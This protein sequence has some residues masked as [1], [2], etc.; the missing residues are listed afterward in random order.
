MNT[1]Q[2][3]AF[4]TDCSAYRAEIAQI[5]RAAFKGR[6]GTGDEEVAI[7]AGLRASGDVIVELAMQ[8]GGQIV[9]HAMFS[10]V[11]ADPPLCRVAALGPVAVR[12]DRQRAGL[13]DSLIRAGLAACRDKGCDAAIVLGDPGYYGRFGFSVELARGI[14]CASAG[15]HFQALEFW[16]GAL[17][18]VTALAY[19]PA[20]Q[21]P[22]L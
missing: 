6:F 17:G 10:P 21:S 15:P 11:A 19:A 2:S 12:I 8:E 7:I 4:L 14:G 13:G 3:A 22:G 5:V 16:P 20:F 9:A 18:G 1:A